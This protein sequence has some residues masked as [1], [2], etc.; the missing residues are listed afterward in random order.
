[1][2]KIFAGIVFFS[3]GLFAAYLSARPQSAE[4]DYRDRASSDPST[5]S[6][7]RES[8]KRLGVDSPKVKEGSA[9]VV[10]D[11]RARARIKIPLTERKISPDEYEE[12]LREAI[13]IGTLTSLQDIRSEYV[14]LLP[15]Y[16]EKVLPLIKRE[17]LD[18]LLRRFSPRDWSNWQEASVSNNGDPS[19]A[20]S[21]LDTVVMLNPNVGRF[22]E[23]AAQL[24]HGMY[25]KF[26]ASKPYSLK[27]DLSY[28]IYNAE[29]ILLYRHSPVLPARLLF[30]V[31]IVND[32]IFLEAFRRE[33]GR[34][35]QER[36]KR[37]PDDIIG[38]LMQIDNA[39]S[40]DA[41]DSLLPLF[42]ELVRR[43]TLEGT[44][45]FR[46]EVI[47]FLDKAEGIKAWS[48]DSEEIRSLNAEL[49]GMSAVDS[50]AEKDIDSARAK[51][52]RSV[53]LHS[54]LKMQSFI[55]KYIAEF[56][57]APKEIID[58]GDLQESAEYDDVDRGVEVEP[59]DNNTSRLDAAASGGSFS[60]QTII[61]WI[62]LLAALGFIGIKLLLLFLA[63]R[64]TR[65]ESGDSFDDDH[66]E[67][68]SNQHADF[69]E[70]E[71]DSLDDI[72]DD[73]EVNR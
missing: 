47:N 64:G 57:Q 23:T 36:I 19:E 32:P 65:M 17:S 22:L 71:F 13:R 67:E 66:F 68:G 61:V 28:I 55:S 35:I 7:L 1:M 37:N 51:L 5:A 2:G 42:S 20:R 21:F 4:V 24:M 52:E 70:L 31:N 15:S 53:A 49:L 44:P 6:D 48:N 40:S 14:E 60:V 69:P 11:P 72:F 30:D 16:S 59:R 10:V 56:D 73:V 8:E 29:D 46:L 62:S 9:E 43:V 41:G 26:R 33:K 39:Y 58:D 3:L 12:K 34:L 54:G 25:M 27:E 18:E 63:K 50:L 38:H 45:A